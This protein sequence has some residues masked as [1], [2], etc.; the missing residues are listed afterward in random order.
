MPT[1]FTGRDLKDQTLRKIRR[2]NN[3]VVEETKTNSS[4]GLTIG[5][6]T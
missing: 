1:V 6:G 5:R 4:V 3:I 2:N